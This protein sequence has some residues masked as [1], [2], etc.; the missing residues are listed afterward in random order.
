MKKNS[1]FSF[2]SVYLNYSYS[3]LSNSY[4]NCPSLFISFFIDA[5]IYY[6][7]SII[8]SLLSLHMNL[9]HYNAYVA[10][11]LVL[12]FLSEFRSVNFPWNFAELCT[13]KSTE[14]CTRK[15]AEENLILKK[16]RLTTVDTICTY[17]VC[18]KNASEVVTKNRLPVSTKDENAIFVGNRCRSWGDSATSTGLPPFSHMAPV[19]KFFIWEIFPHKMTVRCGRAYHI[20]VGSVKTYCKY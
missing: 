20:F 17:R 6:P 8:I 10:D 7:L 2:L 18:D 1:S 3:Y 5:S 11:L 12:V 4:L 19:L 9:Y 14:L 15:S 16:F 13:R